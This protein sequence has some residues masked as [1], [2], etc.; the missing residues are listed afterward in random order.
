MVLSNVINITKEY[1][2]ENS[3]DKETNDKL[4]AGLGTKI[5]DF[6]NVELNGEISNS[7]NKSERSKLIETFEVKAT[8]SVILDEVL[9]KSYP[10]EKFSD[11]KEGE[12]IQIKNL[13][14]SLENE[15][16][17]RTVKTI[18]NGI[19][20]GLQ[21]PEAQGLDINNVFNSILKDYAYRIKG[22]LNND[23]EEELYFKI[24]MSFDSEFESG[25]G[26]DDLFIG[27]VIVLGIYKGK[28]KDSSL[29]TTLDFFNEKENKK[30]SSVEEIKESDFD[31][32]NESTEESKGRPPKEYHFI[33]ILAVLQDIKYNQ[34]DESNGD[35]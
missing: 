23:D 5:F 18:N 9:S 13:K 2:S 15:E 1:T 26:V 12:L 14:L 7:I 6:F 31:N 30:E 3:D 35:S 10:I 16:E 33:D 21:I 32:N 17:L 27:N 8:K 20:E 11:L 25:Y 34:E 29:S 24:P 4:K 28:V 22:R 19:F